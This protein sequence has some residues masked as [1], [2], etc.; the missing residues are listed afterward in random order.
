M[1]INAKSSKSF[2]EKSKD[3]WRVEP[4]RVILKKIIGNFNATADTIGDSTFFEN[5]EKMF[6]IRDF[7]HK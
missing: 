7:K 3:N 1:E 5:T 6:H 4:I 2:I